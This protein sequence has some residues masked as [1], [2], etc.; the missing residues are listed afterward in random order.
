MKNLAGAWGDVSKPCMNGTQKRTLR[1]FA[2]DF[3]AFT[4]DEEVVKINKARAGMTQT[5]TWVWL[6]MIIRS[7][8][9]W[10]LSN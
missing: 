2:H 4:K 6:G 9:R 3:K 8:S 5:L 7:S 10:F 1:R